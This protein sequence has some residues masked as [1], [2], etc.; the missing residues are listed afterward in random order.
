MSCVFCCFLILQASTNKIQESAGKFSESEVQMVQGRADV[1]TYTVLAEMN[2][3]QM[4]R[5]VDFKRYMQGFLSGQIQ[6]YDEVGEL[7]NAMFHTYDSS[8]SD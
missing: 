6:F 7:L 2:H 8:L 5:V 1:I 3:F 4:Q